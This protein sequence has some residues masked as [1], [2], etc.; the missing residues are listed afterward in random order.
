MNMKRTLAALLFTALTGVVSAQPDSAVAVPAGEAKIISYNIR[1]GVADDGSNS[2]ENRREA[3]IRMLERE[4][5]TVFGIQEGYLFQV[6]YI[7]K[8]LP[9]YGRVGVGRD[10]GREKGEMMAVFYLK[11]RYEL[12]EHGDFWLSETPDRVSRGWD[13]ACNRTMTWVHLREKASG[14]EFYYFNTHL[15]HKGEAARREGVKLVVAKI[16]EIAGKRASVVLGGDLNSTI[17]DPI[18]DPLKKFM[19]PAREKAPVTDRKGTYNGWGQAPNSMIIDHL[20]VRN[21]KCLSYR[22]L[23]GDYGVPYISDHYPIEIVVRLK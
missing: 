9:Q 5:P 11:D 7:E 21:L 20:F 23:D 2:W 1:L 12:L 8:H 16:V 17:E 15:D 14:K 10:D 22:T 19:S 4:K 3:T 6:N 13:G 18:F